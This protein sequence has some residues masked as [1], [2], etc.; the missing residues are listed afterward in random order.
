MAK[1]IKSRVNP[2]K[3]RKDLRKSGKVFDEE[4]KLREQWEA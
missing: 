3:L 4:E 2:K 1:K